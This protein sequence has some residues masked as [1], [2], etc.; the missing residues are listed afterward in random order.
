MLQSMGS[1]RVG[2]NRTAEPHKALAYFPG[3]SEAG[4]LGRHIKVTFRE[5]REDSGE[6]EDAG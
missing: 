3:C 5:V 4:R 1:Q 2:H 6:K